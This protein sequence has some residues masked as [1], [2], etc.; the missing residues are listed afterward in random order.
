MLRNALHNHVT[1]KIKLL[2]F[3]WSKELRGLDRLYSAIGHFGGAC[4]RRRYS[5]TV[6][7]Q[8]I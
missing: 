8:N 1:T 6:S 2:G 5:G 3:Q 4:V 7:G